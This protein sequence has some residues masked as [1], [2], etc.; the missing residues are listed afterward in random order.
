[1]CPSVHTRLTPFDK[2]KVP[3]HQVCSVYMCMCVY[4][5]MCVHVYTCMCVCLHIY[6]SIS[7]IYIH[8]YIYIYTY[9][10]IHTHTHTGTDT[11]P[12]AR[13]QTTTVGRFFTYTHIH[14]H[15][16]IH[17]QVLIH[18]LWHGTKQGWTLLGRTPH[19]NIPLEHGDYNESLN[20]RSDMLRFCVT[21][22][23]RPPPVGLPFVWNAPMDDQSRNEKDVAKW[24]VGV[25][26]CT[27]V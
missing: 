23:L 27:C 2:F 7:Y 14:Q 4:V 18:F 24:T 5:C 26:M 22:D 20:I 9:A 6:T 15:T 11:P 19:P 12:L 8:T 21:M 3:V 25:Y 10:N 17:T 16:Y 1:M 13:H